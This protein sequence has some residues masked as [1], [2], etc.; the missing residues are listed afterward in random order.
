MRR[1][2]R[3]KLK[4]VEGCVE[5]GECGGDTEGAADT[6]GSCRYIV[7][8]GVADGE[9]VKRMKRL[10]EIDMKMHRQQQDEAAQGSSEQKLKKLKRS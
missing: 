1:G 9:G 8:V 6:V 2:D 5:G 7:E 3:I 10:L 4:T